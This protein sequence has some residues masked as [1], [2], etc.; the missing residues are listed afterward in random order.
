[1]RYAAGLRR[2]HCGVTVSDIDE[3]RA[4]L[5]SGQTTAAPSAGRWFGLWV[6]AACVVA[7]GAVFLGPR[8]LGLG[9]H[10]G[11]QTTSGAQ[12]P[13]KGQTSVSVQP[14]AAG[15][16][17][18]GTQT[19]SGVGT[20]LN[21]FKPSESTPSF[22]RI[23]EEPPKPPARGVAANYEGKSAAEIGKVADQVCFNRAQTREP[24]R[25]TTPRLTTQSPDNFRPEHMTHFNEL[26]RCLLTEGTR[27]YCVASERRMITAEIA[28]YFRGIESRNKSVKWQFDE[29]RPKT[30]RDV[31]QDAFM[32]GTGQ[33]D[34]ATQ[35][36]R[37]LV[38]VDPPVVAAIEYRLR[39]GLLTKADRDEI[40]AAAP[41][42]LR[43]RFTRIDPPKSSCPDEP[44]WAF[45]R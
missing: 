14:P 8:I 19:F 39:D 43:D 40:A 13:S 9:S 29:N 20:S 12:N 44:W 5:R 25:G 22:L 31:Q 26:L 24:Y 37:A 41:P 10:S 4:S 27:R 45:W 35:L 18:S 15:Q 36:Q 3:I 33:P 32:R 6:V 11:V 38:D 30:M 16:T 17:S 23:G 28:T 7:F 21:E 34:K 2:Q 42:S 1:M